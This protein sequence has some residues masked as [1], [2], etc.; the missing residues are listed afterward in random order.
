MELVNLDHS[1]G[2]SAWPGARMGLTCLMAT[3]ERLTTVDR[4]ASPPG[5]GIGGHGEAAPPGGG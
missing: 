5:L 2:C 3:P 4:L 1:T